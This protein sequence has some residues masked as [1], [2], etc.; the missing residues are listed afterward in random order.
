[1]PQVVSEFAEF[2]DAPIVQKYLSEIVDDTNAALTIAT[3]NMSSAIVR[4]YPARVVGDYKTDLK[5][6][7][8]SYADF[9]DEWNRVISGK[10]R[11]LRAFEQTYQTLLLALELLEASNSDHKALID[12]DV[13]RKLAALFVVLGPVM[14]HGATF[15]K[16]KSDLAALQ[17][18]LTRA[19]TKIAT[20]AVKTALD[21]ALVTCTL[22]VPP[23]GLGGRIAVVVG[24]VVISDSIEAAL[25]SGRQPS[26]QKAAF[27]SSIMAMK[28]HGSLK[29]IPAKALGA[30][31][32]LSKISCDASETAEAIKLKKA[33][34]A[35][36]KALMKTFEAARRDL[37]R[38][39]RSLNRLY[40]DADR[41]YKQAVSN[42]G[43]SVSPTAKR[44][45]LS[46]ELKSA[47]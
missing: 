35:R 10:A 9:N 17:R 37:E 8:S 18:D 6:T 36:I 39:S 30:L 46:K 44:K 13:A 21:A 42:V 16:L 11:D 28:V 12:A 19:K 26:S 14:G 43:Q 32:G 1:M 45:R 5:L 34:D 33:L 47:R 2:L 15:L 38:Q 29:G 3:R 41:A 25:G 20:Q 7:E 24:T 23:L 4:S 31:T 40:Q 27:D 22:L